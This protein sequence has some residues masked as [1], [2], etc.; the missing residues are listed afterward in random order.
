MVFVF[1]LSLPMASFL[2]IFSDAYYVSLKDHQV[3]GIVQ[4]FILSVVK[5]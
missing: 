1:P 4:P 5:N 2:A 3:N